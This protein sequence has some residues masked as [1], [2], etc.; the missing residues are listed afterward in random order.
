MAIPKRGDLDTQAIADEI[1]RQF[2][3]PNGTQSLRPAQGLALYELATQ[4]GL[5]AAIRVGGGK[6]LVSLLA[7]V[8][9]DSRRCLLLLPAA[10]VSK[11][12]RD[13]EEYSRHWRVAKQLRFVSYE[14]LGRP[15][16]A[17]FLDD[18]E[19]DLI[20]A[21]ECHRLK[22]PRA[23]VSKR[24]TRYMRAHPHTRFVALSGTIVKKSIKDYG[25]LAGWALKENSPLPLDKEELEVWADVIDDNEN[26]LLQRDLGRLKSFGRT[27]S[28]I[29][30]GFRERVNQTPG[31][32]TSGQTRDC[33]ASLLLRGVRYEVEDKPRE[34][35]GRLKT[36]YQRLREEWVTPDGWPLADPVS[37]WR[38]ARELALGLHY[39]WDPR[40]PEEWLEARRAWASYCRQIII[41]SRTYDSEG[42]IANACALG[43]IQSS[44]Y[45]A[46][47]ALKKTFVPNT[48]PVWHSKFALN[49]CTEWGRS[50]GGI[51]W[52]AHS[53][54][55]REL[56]KISGYRYFGRK[57]LDDQG[58]AI[59]TTSQE[60]D[61]TV[62]ASLAANGTGR[63]LQSWSRALV[64]APPSGGDTWE[65]LLGRLHRPGQPADEVSFDVFCGCF[66][67]VKSLQDALQQ[68][69]M[70]EATRG[71]PQKLLYC[72]RDYP[73]EPLGTSYAW[74]KEQ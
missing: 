28:E 70:I 41:R 46:W 64:T 54:F 18:F 6:T 38:H 1:T 49:A 3:T 56:A 50:V 7:P 21:D 57:G 60:R 61:G 47:S 63:N 4:G 17:S 55:G 52:S 10:L 29:R 40:P 24:V 51:I 62:V 74:K 36:D 25:H 67:H 42:Q 2:K 72:D 43:E 66:E 8:V 59:E 39:V 5:L 15:Q 69:R 73:E 23:A 65:Q 33:D 34:L 11:T 14:L 9:F 48:Q 19:P 27:A 12:E 68:A 35:N 30:E 32:I 26:F 37:V 16:A 71:E 20:I 45:E 53:F 58:N 22:N 31:V 44:E 13:R